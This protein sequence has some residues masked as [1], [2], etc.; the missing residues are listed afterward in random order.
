MPQTS[1]TRGTVFRDIAKMRL[2]DAAVLLGDRRFN[3]AIYI[4]GYAIECYLK[5]CYCQKRAQ[6]HLPGYLEVHRWDILV[7]AAGVERDLRSSRIIYDIYSALSEA[8]TPD[9]RYATRQLNAVEARALYKRIAQLY[10]Y[11]RELVP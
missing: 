4:A 11:L 9:L 1:G 6:T 10:Q 2:E 8:W 5:Y 7:E 3:G